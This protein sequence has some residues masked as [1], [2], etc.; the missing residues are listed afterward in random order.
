MALTFSCQNLICQS[1]LVVLRGFFVKAPFG[2]CEPAKHYSS[3]I[4]RHEAI[5]LCYRE[6]R[7]SLR[8]CEAISLFSVCHHVKGEI[9][10]YLAMTTLSCQSPLGGLRAQK[11]PVNAPFGGCE[12]SAAISPF[13][14]PAP[15]NRDRHVPRDD[16]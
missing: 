16:R 2:G 7:L 5:S 13:C 14:L 3:V 15:N 8:T 12:R 9:A 11:I 6:R 10:S 1:N 4:A